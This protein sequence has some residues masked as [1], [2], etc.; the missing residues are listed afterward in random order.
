[1]MTQDEALGL[2]GSNDLVH[3]GFRADAIRK[4]LHPDHIISYTV[5]VDRSLDGETGQVAT[6]EVRAQ[7]TTDDRL[8]QLVELRKQQ[9]ETQRFLCFA[10][11]SRHDGEVTASEYM[12]ML[13]IS[14]LYLDNIPHAQVP[15]AAMDTKLAQVAIRFGA[16]D[17]GIVNLENCG[18]T[19][20][21]SEEQV[22]RLIR[23]AGL[24]PKQR[25]SLFQTYFLY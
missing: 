17:L 15:V 4:Q 25:D 9:E 1:M 6:L 10:L 7:S 12:K 18:H 24:I 2:F 20:A 3:L 23:D 5:S 14:R 13:A 19:K 16:N 8:N 11:V 22:R 21:I